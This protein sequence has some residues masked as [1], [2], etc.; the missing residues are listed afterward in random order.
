MLASELS[1]LLGIKH[2]LFPAGNPDITGI[3]NDSRQVKAG[4]LYAA[5]PGAHTDGHLFID[6][7]I[8]RGAVAVICSEAQRVQDD[9]VVTIEVTDPRM[10]LSEASHYIYGRPSEGLVVIGV[11]GTDGKTTTASFVYQML[12]ALGVSA[13]LISS[14]LVDYGE[15]E[16]PNLQHQSTPEAPEIHRILRKMIEAGITHAVIEST[17]HGLSARTCRLAHVHYDAAILTNM[18]QEHLEFHGTFEQY[19]HDKANLFRA[20]DYGCFANAGGIAIADG[21]ASPDNTS[22]L[23]SGI[24]II[25]ADDPVADYFQKACTQQAYLFSLTTEADY[26]PRRIEATAGATRVDIQTPSGLVKTTLSVPGEFNVANLLAAVAVIQQLEDV[27]VEALQTSVGSVQPVNGRMMVIQEQPFTVVVD[28]AHTPGSFNKILPFFRRTTT[29]QLIVVFGSAGERDVKKRP[30]QGALADQYADYV[31][32]TDED[33]RSEDRYAILAGIASGCR[34]LT[35]KSG[36]SLIADRRE[37][38]QAALQ[39][40]NEGDTVLL[41]G[42]GHETSIIGPEGPVPWNEAEVT[43]ELLAQIAGQP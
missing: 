11:T 22:I 40:A 3:T 5:L 6:D 37:A 34:K 27:P 25:N 1:A 39:R 15:G 10:A 32:L 23:K 43:R 31:I 36:L 38:I 8:S 41:L 16:Q 17:S 19:R 13:G 42:K 28:F 30:L 14:A 29:G 4:D 24:A 33:P 2:T 12:R 35:E 20:L 7:A 21:H 26:Y 18:S 9:S